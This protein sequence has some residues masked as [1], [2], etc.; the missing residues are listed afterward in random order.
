MKLLPPSGK[1]RLLAIYFGRLCLVFIIMWIPAFIVMFV[2][3]EWLSPWV[4]WVGGTWSHLQAGMLYMLCRHT[5]LICFLQILIVFLNPSFLLHLEFC[6]TSRECYSFTPQA[7]HLE[8]FQG[9]FMLPL[10]PRAASRFE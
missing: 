9:F 6:Y 8:C 4:D 10:H 1:R 7:R 5:F 2:A 3:T